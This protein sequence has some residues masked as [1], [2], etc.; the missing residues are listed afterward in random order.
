MSSLALYELRC[1]REERERE[2]SEMS[3]WPWPGRATSHQHNN[4]VGSQ[5]Q[6]GERENRTKCCSTA[7][8]AEIIF[9]RINV[10]TERTDS[11]T[12]DVF[13]IPR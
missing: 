3:T 9:V 12:N 1:D 4:D 5:Q 2:L 7:V 6:G 13:K 11:S 10:Q 8:V